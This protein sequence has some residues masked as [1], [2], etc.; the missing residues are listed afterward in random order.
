M[1]CGRSLE[2]SRFLPVGNF[3]PM[4]GPPLY[5]ADD[6]DIPADAVIADSKM[7]AGD[8]FASYSMMFSG[9]VEYVSPPPL[10]VDVSNPEESPVH[11]PSTEILSSNSPSAAPVNVHFIQ[12]EKPRTSSTMMPASESNEVSQVASSSL[13]P[14]P[15]ASQTSEMSNSLVVTRASTS[16]AAADHAIVA[17]TTSSTASSATAVT[18]QASASGALMTTVISANE[19]VISAASIQSPSIAAAL[20]AAN[21]SVDGSGTGI[22]VRRAVP[23][24]SSTTF[25]SNTSAVS[26]PAPRL[27]LAV[28]EIS[29]GPSDAVSLRRHDGSRHQTL[30]APSGSRDG[31]TTLAA[32][33]EAPP[34]FGGFSSGIDN[35]NNESSCAFN[36]AAMSHTDESGSAD[37][38]VSRR[39]DLVDSAEKSYSGAK[40]QA[41]AESGL[42]GRWGESNRSDLAGGKFIGTHGSSSDMGLSSNSHLAISSIHGGLRNPQHSRAASTPSVFRSEAGGDWRPQRMGDCVGDDDSVCE[43][44]LLD[45]VA[46]EYRAEER[47]LRGDVRTFNK[48]ISTSVGGYAARGGIVP[49]SLCAINPAENGTTTNGGELERAI[50]AQGFMADVTVSATRAA[51]RNGNPAVS[52][53]TAEAFRR[54]DF[55]GV[56]DWQNKDERS[57]RSGSYDVAAKPSAEV[58]GRDSRP[59]EGTIRRL[60][61]AECRACGR[62]AGDEVSGP[63]CAMCPEDDA[64][65][66]VLDEGHP[67]THVREFRK[68][69][70]DTLSLL[71]AAVQRRDASG[72]FPGTP[73]VTVTRSEHEIVY[74]SGDSA[75][76]AK[77]ESSVA[78]AET[79]SLMSASARGLAVVG[80]RS[81]GINGNTGAYIFDPKTGAMSPA[82]ASSIAADPRTIVPKEVL[83]SAINPLSTRAPGRLLEDVGDAPSEAT[84]APR[85]R[86][87]SMMAEGILAIRSRGASCRAIAPDAM[88]PVDHVARRL[89]DGQAEESTCGDQSLLPEDRAE[90][91]SRLLRD[92]HIDVGQ[93][94]RLTPNGRVVPLGGMDRKAPEVP[95]P[96][97]S[98]SASRLPGRAIHL[99]AGGAVAVRPRGVPNSI[100]GS[101]SEYYAHDGSRGVS[102]DRDYNYQN[103]YG[104]LGHTQGQTPP[105]DAVFA[106]GTDAFWRSDGTGYN[107]DC[108]VSG[109]ACRVSS[110]REGPIGSSACCSVGIHGDSDAQLIVVAPQVPRGTGEIRYEEDIHAAIVKRGSQRTS[111]RT[112]PRE[113]SAEIG[114]VRECR[115]PRCCTPV[116]NAVCTVFEGRNRGAENAMMRAESYRRDLKEPYANDF[117][118]SRPGLLRS[119]Q[120]TSAERSDAITG[121]KS[122]S[123]PWLSVPHD[124]GRPGTLSRNAPRDW[125]S[126]ARE[127]S[128]SRLCEESERHVTAMAAEGAHV[129]SMLASADRLSAGRVTVAPRRGRAGSTSRPEATQ[130]VEASRF[131]SEALSIGRSIDKEQQPLGWYG[132]RSEDKP[133]RSSL[134]GNAGSSSSS[135][136]SGAVEFDVTVQHSDGSVR[137]LIPHSNS[138][139][140]RVSGATSNYAGG[141]GGAS[142]ITSKASRQNI[143]KGPSHLTVADFDPE[144]LVVAPRINAARRGLSGW[145]TTVGVGGEVVLP[146]YQSSSI[147]ALRSVGTGTAQ[148]NVIGAKNIEPYAVARRASAAAESRGSD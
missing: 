51:G 101:A 130:W 148:G 40:S 93:S 7:S 80:V 48:V 115:E 122:S 53:A 108:C 39:G 57:V 64:M 12:Y 46:E 21:I 89:L 97:V 99:T 110:C 137:P 55:L 37:G 4:D 135:G 146:A 95:R 2:A 30:L 87:G 126:G 117:P 33:S 81:K 61:R 109:S 142:L 19:R 145:R 47:P 138:N 41:D 35:R 14:L 104:R 27:R 70:T 31:K 147:S 86:T 79:A 116:N 9:G 102:R 127:E 124:Y 119:D 107:G 25:E 32:I 106:A 141:R 43:R 15:T 78:N 103:R 16:N 113:N 136:N 42:R 133:L 131:A 22:V 120:V 98:T 63:P 85:D 105:S 8:R 91:V 24:S 76:K 118:G 17:A 1:L 11:E 10:P 6:E 60:R 68:S 54:E 56:E 52:V 62:Q 71:P 75:S 84:F 111:I 114:G 45:D 88:T 74:N 18:A 3:V 67:E 94:L 58:L 26:S 72:G 59:G 66:P 144:P 132:A 139:R 129:S 20:A 34:P 38:V 23:Y 69:A 65:E 13:Q 36:G 134:R 90:G 92:V 29:V 100:G 50:H 28:R 83:M 5:L 123:S 96:S 73:G 140:E 125:R 77:V 49:T 128:L 82:A 143:V 44:D 121:E 112:P